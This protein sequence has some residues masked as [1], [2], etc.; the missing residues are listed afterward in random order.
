MKQKI[1]A[2]DGSGN[3]MLHYAARQNNVELIE[4][5]LAEGADIN[6]VN[7]MGQNSLQIAAEFGNNEAFKILL[8]AEKSSQ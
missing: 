6:A 3:M 4:I 7:M 2:V 5:L 8:A 1:N